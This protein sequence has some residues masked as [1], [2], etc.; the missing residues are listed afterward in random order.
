MTL[1]EIRHV[2]GWCAVINLGLLVWWAFFILVA[3]DWT[4]RMHRRFY[5]ISEEAFDTIHYAGIGLFKIVVLV[6]NVVPYLAL[7]IVG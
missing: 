2:L 7:R 5:R 3:R 4:Y 6:F 1:E